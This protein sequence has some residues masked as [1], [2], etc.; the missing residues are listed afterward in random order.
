MEKK[1]I[2][3]EGIGGLNSPKEFLGRV[4]TGKGKPVFTSNDILDYLN[5]MAKTQN[6]IERMLKWSIIQK[7]LE[8]N[9]QN[10]VTAGEMQNKEQFE[11]CVENWK[12]LK[13]QLPDISDIIEG[14]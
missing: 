1:K 7:Q 6:R 11:K 4:A 5:E 12:D 8:I 13:K 10:R 14:K 2:G 9:H 3:Y